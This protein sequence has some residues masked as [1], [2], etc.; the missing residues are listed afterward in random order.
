VFS[1]TG[2]QA[3]AGFSVLSTTNAADALP[4][5]VLSGGTFDSS[6]NFSVT[7]AI[8]PDEQKRFFLISVP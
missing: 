8:T 5:P 2:G 3:G 6:G 7:N 4:W 1:G